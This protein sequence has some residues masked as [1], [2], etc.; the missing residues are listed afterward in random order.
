MADHKDNSTKSPIILVSAR[1]IAGVAELTSGV[2]AEVEVLHGLQ[3][4]HAHD[5]DKESDTEHGRDT[6]LL[7]SRQLQLPDSR[8]RQDQ[9]RYVRKHIDT[10]I[11]PSLPR[12]ARAFAMVFAVP[13]CPAV[14]DWPAFEDARQFEAN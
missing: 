10:R 2:G 6:Q 3:A 13:E 8:Q 11:G 14:T 7:L 9:D 5:S 12:H 4:D 1:D